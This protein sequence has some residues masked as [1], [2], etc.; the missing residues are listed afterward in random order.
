M[1]PRSVRNRLW[2]RSTQKRHRHHGR[3]SNKPLRRSERRPMPSHA[4]YLGRALDAMQ[5][6]QWA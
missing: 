4:R 6:Y 3:R 5:L 2:R 1:F